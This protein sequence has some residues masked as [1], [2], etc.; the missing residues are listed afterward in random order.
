MLAECALQTHLLSVDDVHDNAALEHPRKA[1]LD[2][3]GLAARLLDGA[4]DW[5][6]GGHYEYVVELTGGRKS[7]VG[8]VRG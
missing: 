2:E 6:R 8:D 4:V 7:G 3:E 1:G 5:E